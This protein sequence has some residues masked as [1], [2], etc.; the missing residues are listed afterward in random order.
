MQGVAFAAPALGFEEAF[1]V[2]GHFWEGGMWMWW[3]L[4]VFLVPMRPG[5]GFGSAAVDEE[6]RD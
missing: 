3:V 2:F 1:A 5:G 4:C 6:V